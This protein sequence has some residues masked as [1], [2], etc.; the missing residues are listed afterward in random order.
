M[1]YLKKTM[2]GKH[3]VYVT[4]CFSA[5]ILSVS[6]Y[7]YFNYRLYF[8]LIKLSFHESQRR[9]GLVA[10]DTGVLAIA[11][12]AIFLKLGNVLHSDLL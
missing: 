10:I 1:V 6:R 12:P 3:F 9:L 8:V 7:P 4:V 2:E 11:M 5:C